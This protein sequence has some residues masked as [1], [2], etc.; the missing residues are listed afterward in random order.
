MKNF[1]DGQKV[2]AALLLL[3]VVV[4]YFVV[5]T[6]GGP[7]SVAHPQRAQESPVP[8]SGTDDE[9]VE[10]S[11]DNVN[12]TYF[13]RVQ[14]LKMQIA[15][16]PEDTTAMRELARLYQDAHQ[17]VESATLYERYLAL[18]PDSKQEWLDLAAVYAQTT[19]WVAA[20]STMV[21]TLIRFPDDPAVQY[22]VGAIRANQSDYQGAREWWQKV[23]TQNRDSDLRDR[24]LKS[25][26][27]IPG[28]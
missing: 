19:D 9:A 11:K 20:E 12:H 26:Q 25:L 3:V 5:R 16:A 18:N 27:K 14:R 7:D 10:P 17:S 1:S 22:N 23:A 2:G 4:V 15:D 13:Q 28:T 21:R 6:P 24:A 8:S